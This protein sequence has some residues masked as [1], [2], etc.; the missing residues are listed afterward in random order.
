M[1]AM[2]EEK[3]GL[4]RTMSKGE[5][6]WMLAHKGPYSAEVVRNIVNSP[7]VQVSDWAV[8]AAIAYVDYCVEQY[9][10]CPVHF[11]P[12]QCNFGA[13]IHHVDPAF[14]ERYYDG[15][16]VTPQIRQHMDG[17]H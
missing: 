6:N 15:S 17:W 11:N 1:T 8:E 4:G 2:M 13:V 14:Y 9:G 7:A 5:D 3:Y 16:S 12:M 10:Q